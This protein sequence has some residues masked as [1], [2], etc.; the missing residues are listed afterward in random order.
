MLTELFIRWT[1]SVMNTKCMER[2]FV[3]GVANR[4]TMC[5]VTSI[6]F[7]FIDRLSLGR[8]V[9]Y[10]ARLMTSTTDFRTSEMV[11]TMRRRMA[12][13]TSK[14][15]AIQ[16]RHPTRLWQ[17]LLVVVRPRTQAVIQSVTVVQRSPLDP[18]RFQCGSS[19]S[20]ATQRKIT[21]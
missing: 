3:P 15:P 6:T 9:P 21:W 2:A 18:F 17:H 14:P 20:Q 1:R 12:L 5:H 13:P 8:T 10:V 4:A 16:G 11:V 7:V 19:V